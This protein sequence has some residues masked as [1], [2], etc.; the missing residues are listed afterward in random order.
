VYYQKCWNEGASGDA[1][2][3]RTGAMPKRRRITYPGFAPRREPRHHALLLDI[4]SHDP[5][6][7]V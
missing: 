4:L 3:Y 6:A 2:A 5:G 1:L 7:F